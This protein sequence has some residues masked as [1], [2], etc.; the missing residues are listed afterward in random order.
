MQ[1]LLSPAL[2]YIWLQEQR[3]KRAAAAAVP[4]PVKPAVP[5]PA[6]KV[7]RPKRRDA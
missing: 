2:V 4:Q 6:A 3:R 5:Q 1:S 7:D